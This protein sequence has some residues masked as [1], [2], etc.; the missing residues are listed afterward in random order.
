MWP[1]LAWQMKAINL[2]LEDGEG[3]RRAVLLEEMTTE[4]AL[5]ERSA[6]GR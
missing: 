2:E 3:E 1:L 4:L 5:P 6:V